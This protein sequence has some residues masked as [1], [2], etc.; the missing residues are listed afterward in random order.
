MNGTPN[1]ELPSDDCGIESYCVA[2][3][4]T[5]FDLCSGNPL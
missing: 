4:G 1:H 2:A 3:I 5:L